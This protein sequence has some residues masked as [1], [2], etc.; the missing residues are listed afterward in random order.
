M[1]SNR[2]QGL[3]VPL[4]VWNRK[5]VGQKHQASVLHI[6]VL[7]L[8][9]FCVVTGS[10]DGS[11]CLWRQSH[12][13]HNR[14]YPFDLLVAHETSVTGLDDGANE[15]AE[16]VIASVS[17]DGTVCLWQIQ[18]G[19]CLRHGKRIAEAIQPVQSLGLFSNGR[20]AVVGGELDRQLLILDTWSMTVLTSVYCHQQTQP[21]YPVFHLAIAERRLS[22]SKKI[23]AHSFILS[24]NSTGVVKSIK[25]T[26]VVPQ[27]R[28]PVA[29]SERKS[30][31][32]SPVVSPKFNASVSPRWEMFEDSACGVGYSLP[33][34]FQWDTTCAWRI[35][36]Q[37]SGI[38][39]QHH[40]TSFVP[41]CQLGQ[42]LPIR[43]SISPEGLYILFLWPRQWLVIPSYC[44]TTASMADEEVN[45]DLVSSTSWYSMTHRNSRWIGAAFTDHNELV[46]WDSNGSLCHFALSSQESASVKVKFQ[47]DQSVTSISPRHVEQENVVL[48]SSCSHQNSM[49]EP[50]D[51][52]CSATGIEGTKVMAQLCRTGDC[53]TAGFHP[54]IKQPPEP[55]VV[56]EKETFSCTLLLNTVSI[57][58]SSSALDGNHGGRSRDSVDSSLGWIV[59]G[60]PSGSITLHSLGDRSL[61]FIVGEQEGGVSCLAYYAPGA[62]EHDLNDDSIRFLT[63]RDSEGTSTAL[64]TMSLLFS[65]VQDGVKQAMESARDFSRSPG[66][67]GSPSCPSPTSDNKRTEESISGPAVFVLFSGSTDGS[68]SVWELHGETEWTARRLSTFRCH[69]DPITDICFSPNRF[70]NASRLMCSVGQD[71]RVSLFRIQMTMG[72]DIIPMFEFQ[73]HAE[74]IVSINWN[75]SI[76]I[77]SL[78]V[79]CADDLIYVW[80]LTTGVLERCIPS[81]MVQTSPSVSRRLILS[82]AAVSVHSIEPA[83]YLMTFN[84]GSRPNH[85]SIDLNLLA[86]LHTWGINTEID[87]LCQE[88]LGLT[89]R[90]NYTFALPGP[91]GALT[92]AL[93]ND[94]WKHSS[95][96]TALLQLSVVSLCLNLM[97]MK[98]M[99][100]EIQVLWSRLI[101]QY[102]VELPEHDEYQEFFN[103][104]FVLY[105]FALHALDECK[106]TQM[107]ARLL[108]Q[109]VIQRMDSAR[110]T[111]ACAEW[112]AKLH[113]AVERHL[114]SDHLGIVNPQLISTYLT[115]MLLVLSLIGISNPGD[116]SPTA[117]RQVCDL[118]LILLHGE[119][120]D[121]FF[122]SELLAKGLAL[123]RPHLQDLHSIVRQ[124]ISLT[125]VP[126]TNDDESPN[127]K[128]MVTRFLVELGACEPQVFI[129]IIRSEIVKT[130]SK[131]DRTRCAAVQCLMALLQNHFILLFRY[132][133][134]IVETIVC[135]LDPSKPLRRKACLSVS[136]KALHDIVRK[137]PMIAFHKE[138]QRLG[139]GTMES[140]IIIYDLRTATK[141]RVL[142]GHVGSI[143]AL[144]FSIDGKVLI[145]YSAKECSVRWWKSGSSGLF[146]G[147]LA[148]Q[149]R[150]TKSIELPA[151]R[152]LDLNDVI[153]HCR[154]RNCSNQ[155]IQLT[156]EDGS[157]LKLN[158]L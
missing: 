37:R 19:Q 17:V 143:S 54:L 61:S 147:L 84:L 82:N 4:V 150:C 58:G 81:A 64:D 92:V 89:Y 25:W 103:H 113:C 98:S 71:R 11:I 158:V 69:T 3:H 65:R 99:E 9:R 107:A 96:L 112:A 87:L 51:Y 120:K 86:Y 117:A 149:T 28:S 101:T 109:G 94:L 46:C 155:E 74:E 43:C 123:W 108:L 16:P 10:K 68:L 144:A 70:C 95:S 106:Y 41:A 100:K 45:C 66:M 50:G 88:H 157:I 138:S 93:E 5:N 52:L 47:T 145:S 60:T 62:F 35:T 139:V 31:R 75:Y 80:S 148:M 42:E 90:N 102:S 49:L 67:R 156:R 30:N 57:F 56:V 44:I 131:Y 135:S 129:G 72:F 23:D 36:S 116:I 114:G 124:L 127:L 78:L 18:D 63:V 33:G 130:E 39:V 20:Y 79:E 1:S 125:I 132:I 55:P 104:P 141:W 153:R 105:T 24:L 77:G 142:E 121:A 97:Q 136:T 2:R 110:R 32:S 12:I 40:T 27:H 154:F 83:A 119:S 38:S 85:S 134:A 91:D 29:S 73:S 128:E 140:S 7:G 8:K 137:F 115:P 146:S 13:N 122:A 111:T 53:M 21:Q 118:L 26:A 48:E 59:S 151:T 22:I 34:D 15:W 6:V 152:K 133:P 76:G 14:V 126:E